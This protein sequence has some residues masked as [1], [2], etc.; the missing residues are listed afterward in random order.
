MSYFINPVKEDQCL[1]LTYE[2]EMPPI[3]VVAVRYEAAGLLAEK[4]WNR[5]VVDITELRPVTAMELFV[6][7]KGLSADLPPSARIA[8]VVRPEQTK[9]ARIVE[10][11]ARNDGAFM[12]CF[13]DADLATTWVKGMKPREQTQTRSVEKRL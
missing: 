4:H 1:F 3:E 7:A 5:M 10:N 9:E 2:G 8:L 12:S 13:F 6:F 11:V